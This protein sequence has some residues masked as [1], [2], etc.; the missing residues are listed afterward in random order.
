M[1][2]I[3][4]AIVTFLLI[5]SVPVLARPINWHEAPQPLTPLTM[6]DRNSA[7][8][9]LDAFAGRV[10]VLNLWATWCAPC[11]AEMP[12]LAALQDAFDPEDVIVVALAVDQAP[13]ATLDGFMAEV[14]AANLHV[15]RDPQGAAARA[16]GVAGLPVTLVID[17]DGRERLRHLGYADWGTADVVDAVGAL[18]P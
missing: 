7:E 5:V 3:L 17:G 11:R 13:W 4:A 8:V 14:A 15:L 9:G 2:V 1:R 16:L 10:V 12:T 18:V 6:V